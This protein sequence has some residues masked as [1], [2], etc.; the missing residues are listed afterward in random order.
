MRLTIVMAVFLN[1]MRGVSGVITTRRLFQFLKDFL[2]NPE[3]RDFY[4]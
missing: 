3:K 2:F 4:T 1:I